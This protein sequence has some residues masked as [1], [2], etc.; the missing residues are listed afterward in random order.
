MQDFQVT[1]ALKI[2]PIRFDIAEAEGKF[3]DY[4]KTFFKCGIVLF[5][6]DSYEKGYHSDDIQECEI[7]YAKITD[8]RLLKNYN[9]LYKLITLK[10]GHLL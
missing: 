1:K 5:R 2:L 9:E 4:L 6:R 7:E 8:D 10:W 3:P